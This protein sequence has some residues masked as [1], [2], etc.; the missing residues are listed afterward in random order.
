VS[1]AAL[2]D[3][4][5][6]SPPARRAYAQ[7]AKAQRARQFALAA[8]AYQRAM[9]LDPNFASAYQKYFAAKELAFSQAND[10][11]PDAEQ[12]K[13]WSEFRKGTDAEMDALM[14]RQPPSPIYPWIN[15]TRYEEDAPE[16]KREL[17]REARAVDP[18][19]LPAYR[20]LAQVALLGGDVK[21]AAQ[22][23]RR[24][25]DHN[26][27]D[28]E[29]WLN[30]T[31]LVRS[32][33]VL[34]RSAVDEVR[35]RFP[36]SNTAAQA[37]YFFATAQDR[38][39][40]QVDTLSKLIGEYSI[41]KY[42]SAADA[43]TRVFELED[44]SDPDAARRLAHTCLEKMGK[45][46]DWEAAAVYADAMANAG[47]QLAAA[48]AAEAL[49]TLN[50]IKTNELPAGAARLEALRARAL[51]ASGDS[52]GAYRLLEQTFVTTPSDI[53]AT[54]LYEIGQRLGKSRAEVDKEVETLRAGRAK[55]A[56][57]FSLPAFTGGTISL[58]DYKGR[59]V[60]LDFWFPNCGPCRASFPYVRKLIDKYKDNDEVAF[61]AI[62]AIAGQ[63]PFVM[64]L[65]QS[66][67]I[68]WLPLK[69]DIEWCTGVYGVNAFPTTFLIGRDGKIYF[70]PR[71]RNSNGERSTELAIDALLAMR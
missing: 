53:A 58:G 65:L 17:C 16:K 18:N 1:A 60:V 10:D 21:Q 50:A 23:F 49:A 44:E 48:R 47:Q 34:F 40:D 45:D 8:D 29:S 39:A 41:G 27:K 63:E 31:Y 54:A 28:T 12:E 2:P 64:P 33:P 32:D 66:E 3:K 35:R 20:C 11:K 37:Q 46:K 36:H 7:G 14:A 24:V 51:E 30:Y 57:Q 70:K 56:K 13:V 25:L 19:F 9:K 67:Q 59:V 68:N 52:A 42:K 22:L 55:P 69:G 71:V 62:N 26:Q 6:G 5:S 38:P 4:Y 15:S 61:L 43:A